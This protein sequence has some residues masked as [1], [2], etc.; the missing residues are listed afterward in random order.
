MIE[1]TE[2]NGA[3]WLKPRRVT[4]TELHSRRISTCKTL[5][6]VLHKYPDIGSAHAV[7]ERFVFF[8]CLYKVTRWIH[9][10]HELCPCRQRTFSLSR[11]VQGGDMI[12]M[13]STNAV[14]ERFV[15]FE[16][17]YKITKWRHA[18]TGFHY[19]LALTLAD[20]HK[21][22]HLIKTRT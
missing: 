4:C 13:S 3:V 10:L 7:N 2:K 1:Q 18:S 6:F 8:Q 5:N 14:N 21:K 11:S 19:T 22:F 16:C 12:C 17:L 9:A 20:Q 15:F